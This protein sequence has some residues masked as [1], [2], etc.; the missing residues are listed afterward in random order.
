MSAKIENYE[1]DLREGTNE[2]SGKE[3]LELYHRPDIVSQGR[4][5]G[6]DG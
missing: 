2:N 5:I 3:L 4:R 6:L 1:D